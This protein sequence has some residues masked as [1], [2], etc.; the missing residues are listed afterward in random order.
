MQ[1]FS[2]LTPLPGRRAMPVRGERRNG[3]CGTMYEQKR[4][5]LV[6]DDEARIVR[7][8]RDLLTARGFHVLTAGSGRAALR[9]GA[10]R[11][12]ID[13][14]LLDVMMPELDGFAVLRELRRQD[15]GLPAILLT[16][17]G[18]NTISSWASPP[19][20]TTTFP[21]P[22]PPRFSWPGWRRFC[23]GAG[24]RRRKACGPARSS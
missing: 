14:V 24:G 20:R 19:A 5:V 17:R 1:S 6:A 16:A 9:Y 3:G 21:S 13:L 23:A 22:S 7:A 15:P 8:L 2:R 11:E 10:I 4:C 12:Q 18:R